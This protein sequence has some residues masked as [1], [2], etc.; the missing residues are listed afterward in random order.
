METCLQLTNKQHSKYNVLVLNSL[1]SLS[2]VDGEL[3]ASSG[4]AAVVDQHA[5]Q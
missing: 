1:C 4:D 3:A 5:E 2:V